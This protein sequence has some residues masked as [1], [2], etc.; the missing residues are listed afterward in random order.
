MDGGARK[1]KTDRSRI[2]PI[3]T[4][5]SYL[6]GEWRKLPIEIGKK[7]NQKPSRV[8]ILAAHTL[9]KKR[10][11]DIMTNARAALFDC[12]AL[13]SSIAARTKRG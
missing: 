1:C 8:K 7:K 6:G 13:H 3:D 5:V 4:S 12:Y 9:S 11:Q 10:K 2:G